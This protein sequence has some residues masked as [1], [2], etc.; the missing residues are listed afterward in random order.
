MKRLAIIAA[1]GLAMAASAEPVAGWFQF[2]DAAPVASGPVFESD[3]TAMWTFE[4]ADF[5][6]TNAN[7]GAGNWLLTGSPTQSGGAIRMPFARLQPRP[8][9][10]APSNTGTIAFMATP[11]SAGTNEFFFIQGINS[12]NNRISVRWLATR[13]GVAGSSGGEQW[14]GEILSAVVQT[15]LASK[16]VVTWEPGYARAYLLAPGASAATQFMAAAGTIAWTNTTVSVGGD[17]NAGRFNGAIHEWRYYD[18]V[19]SSNESVQV[20]GDMP[21]AGGN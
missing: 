16:I 19:L 12:P 21:F 4:T 11:L 14:G 8:I 15:N 18:R 7:Y 5:G 10:V 13:W 1:A 6:W 20:I 17:F 2:D 3:L 9:D